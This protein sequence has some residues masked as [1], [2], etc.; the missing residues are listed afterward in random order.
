MYFSSPQLLQF[1]N[2]RASL[3]YNNIVN[4]MNAKFLERKED[5]A[6]QLHEQLEQLER[7]VHT[8]LVGFD[9]MLDDC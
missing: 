8:T 7:L 5:A 1:Q 3:K 4:E 2:N 9:R 6:L